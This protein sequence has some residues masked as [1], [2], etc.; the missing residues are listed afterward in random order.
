MGHL[1]AVAFEVRVKPL[2]H[3]EVEVVTCR[4]PRISMALTGIPDQADR[5]LWSAHFQVTEKL[6]RLTGVHARI[7][8]PMH[9]Q[10]RRLCLVYPVDGT[11]LEVTLPV[12]PDS[13][14]CMHTALSERSIPTE[15]I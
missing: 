4:S 11:A 10:Q 2:H 8:L 7:F 13:C 1:G 5:H 14:P 9:N 6:K 3:A 12:F 15:A